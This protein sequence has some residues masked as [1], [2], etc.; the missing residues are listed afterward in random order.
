LKHHAGNEGGNHRTELPVRTFGGEESRLPRSVRSGSLQTSLF[1]NFFYFL[2]SFFFEKKLFLCRGLPDSALGKESFLKKIL[3]SVF[4]FL[5]KI[6]FAEGH[7]YGTR[8]SHFLIIFLLK[9][10]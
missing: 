10:F 6:R 4:I 7:T 2:F 8:Q 5:K 9:N 3:F 1:L